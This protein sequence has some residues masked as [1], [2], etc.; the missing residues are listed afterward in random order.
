[1]GTDENY[2]SYHLCIA[3]DIESGAISY[4]IFGRAHFILMSMEMQLF[5]TVM[6]N[7]EITKQMLKIYTCVL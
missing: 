7:F 4:D 5:A 1:M 3:I 2:Q 6:T